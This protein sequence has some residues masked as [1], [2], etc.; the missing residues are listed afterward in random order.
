V[1][2]RYPCAAL[3]WFC[4]GCAEKPSASTPARTP[5]SVPSTSNQAGLAWAAPLDRD[6][7]LV[8]KVWAARE[9]AMVAES[10]LFAA[11]AQARFLLLGER[12]DNPDHQRLQARALSA[13]VRAGRRPAVVLEM[14]E[15]GSQDVVDRYRA[16]PHATSA[17]FGAAVGWQETSWPPYV[18]YQPIL[19]VV[20]EAKLPVVAGNLAHE[21]ARALVKQ[22]PGAL[23]EAKRKELRLDQAFP[24][25]LEAPLIEELRAS[26]CGHLPEAL[27]AP[28]ALAQHARD[29]QMARALLGASAETA[30]LIA[31]TGH[32]RLDRGVPH[33]LALDA[34]DAAVVSVALVEVQTGQT[35]PASYARASGSASAPFH[36]FWFTPRLT[37]ED[38]CAAFKPKP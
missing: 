29:A 22:G 11:M 20:F 34:P 33:Y 8:G 5:A 17:G 27:L 9:G 13:V 16:T 24:A 4:I 21:A 38:P 23:P 14:L 2:H 35:D 7:P 26:H 15:T 10:Q 25:E 12:H 19:D 36:Y 28:M 30:V 37:D 32:V 6:H 3:L 1:R 18:E 31:G